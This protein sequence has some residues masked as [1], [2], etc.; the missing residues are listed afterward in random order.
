MIAVLFDKLFTILNLSTPPLRSGRYAQMKNM[1]LTII[2]FSFLWGGVSAFQMNAFLRK[3]GGAFNHGYGPFGPFRYLTVTLE[4]H[5]KPG[6]W[7]I[8]FLCSV[9]LGVAAIVTIVLLNA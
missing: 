5:G 1:L 3:Q 9:L 2:T 8:S 4:A 7:F 6:G